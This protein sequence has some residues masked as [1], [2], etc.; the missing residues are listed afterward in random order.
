ML[1]LLRRLLCGGQRLLGTFGKS[2]K[3]HA[4]LIPPPGDG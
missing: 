4:A 2:I 3:S 1:E